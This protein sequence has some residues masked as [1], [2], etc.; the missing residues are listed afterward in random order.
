MRPLD[1]FRTIKGK[2]S[3]VI[4]FAVGM[5]MGVMVLLVRFALTDPADQWWHVVLAGAASAGVGLGLARVLA[6]GLTK[7]LRDIASATEQLSTGDHSH[8][9]TIS[10]NDEVGRLAESFNRMAEQLEGLENLRRDL[11]ANVSHELKTPI[12]A[13]QAHIENLLDGVESVNPELLSVMLQQ[14]QR[15][16]RLVDQLLDLSRLESGEVPL[17]V[18]PLSLGEVV[19][20]VAAEVSLARRAEDVAIRNEIGR[21]VNVPADRERVHQVLYNLLEN[22]S[23]FSPPG[24]EVVV[25]GRHSNGHYSV[26]VCD[27]G[28]GIPTEQLNLV[29]ERFYRVD[30]ARNRRDGGTGI[31]LAIARSV[32]EA[33]GGDIS[34]SNDPDGG[35]IFRFTLPLEAR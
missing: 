26:E 12:S 8:R 19:D 34:A 29:F 7:P 27:E 10:T 17:H 32:V 3:F 14:S 25:R 9:V 31:G 16:G 35:A 4:V 18:A 11:I 30:P 15:L 33:H 13:L 6:V 20:E 2:L 23:R 21:D 28:P 1:R 22:A 24:G 5:T